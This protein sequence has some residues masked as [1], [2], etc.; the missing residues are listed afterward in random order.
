MVAGFRPLEAVVP[1]LAV[2]A[3]ATFVVLGTSLA[4]TALSFTPRSWLAFAIG[5]LLVGLTYACVGVIAGSLFGQLGAT[6][7]ALFAAMLGTGI[8]QD[9]M[10]GSGTPSGIAFFLPDYGAVRV[11]V[12]GGFST[13]FT[14]WGEL[15]L[16]LGWL[17]LLVGVV[18][19][20]L[21]RLLHP[22]S[23]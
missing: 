23:G 13:S 5:T 8:L 11:V 18:V 19:V 7:L 15:G 1:R 6:Y 9:P 21:R 4:V 16:A 12:D 14:A 10:F 3:A 20:V 2:L 22:R 17:V